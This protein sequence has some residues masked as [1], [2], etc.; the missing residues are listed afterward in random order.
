MTILGRDAILGAS[1]IEMREVDVPEWGGSVMVKGLSGTERD[2]YEASCTQIRGKQT[3]PSLANVRAKLLARAIV[4]QDGA[5]L[6][7]PQDVAALG[8]KNGAVLDRLFDVAAELSG[9][10]DE[11]VDELSGNSDAAQSGDSTSN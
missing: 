11:A 4:D 9:L 2:E 1:D 6:F 3:V 8:K 5:R 10:T 7:S